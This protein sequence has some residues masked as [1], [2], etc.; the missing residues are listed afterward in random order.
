MLGMLDR[1][2]SFLPGPSFF[3]VTLTSVILLVP[4]SIS[5]LERAVRKGLGLIY[6]RAGQLGSLNLQRSKG[7]ASLTAGVLIVVI[8]MV[9][10]IGAMRE[11]FQA[12]VDRWV[13]TFTGIDFYIYSSSF[14]PM[15]REVGREIAQVEGIEAVTPVR[16][17][18]VKM[19]GATGPTGFKG[20]PR[21]VLLKVL[22]PE[23]YRSVSEICL[24]KDQS[25]VN[26]I[27]AQFA[28]GG[29]VLITPNI[30]QI[31]GI[32]Q[33]DTIRLRTNRGEQD[34]VVAGIIV[35]MSVGGQVI[36]GSWGDMRKYFGENKANYFAVK[37]APEAHS[38]E[39]QMRLEEIAKRLHLKIYTGEAIRRKTRQDAAKFF[40]IFNSMIFVAMTLAVLSLTNTMTMNVLERVREIGILRS[41][42]MTKRQVIRM[43]MGEAV[44]IGMISV[45]F[46]LI[47]GVP[48]SMVMVIGMNRTGGW[49][50]DYV[51]PT[52]AF[53]WGILVALIVSQ[54]AALYAGRRATRLDI[55][56]ALRY[57]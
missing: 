7:R 21:E 12:E 13:E 18:F 32:R 48:I 45:V 2:F 11:S 33:G 43:V 51:F 27:F 5:R 14:A 38:D 15:R 49:Q 55:V 50:L 17:M 23:T 30:Q 54:A 42:G 41:V 19:M 47:V 40:A 44:A 28:Q 24:A 4:I 1:F 16:I 22:D 37:L 10:S 20:E 25:Q 57:E 6:G 8:V 34:F 53:G 26:Q 31:Y 29:S 52:F 9:I 3:I 56:E 36:T 39:V 46:S 35:S